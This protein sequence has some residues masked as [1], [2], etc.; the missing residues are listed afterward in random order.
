[1]K[2]KIVLRRRSA[3]L[4][5]DQAADHYEGDAGPDVALRFVDAVESAYRTIGE[6]PSA[7]SSLW[8]EQLGIAGLRSRPVAHFPYL[9]FYLEEDEH[10]EVWRVLHARRDIPTSLNAEED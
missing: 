9:I 6:R 3:R 1:M 10:I 2:A 4:D 5:L 8:A 7:G